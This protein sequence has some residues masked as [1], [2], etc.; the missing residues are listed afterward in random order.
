MDKL[1][2]VFSL[3]AFAAY[4]YAQW[5]LGELRLKADKLQNEIN[6]IVYGQ[7]KQI[8]KEITELQKGSKR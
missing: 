3:V 2:L 5:K 1:L 4:A 8:H 7:I 6:E